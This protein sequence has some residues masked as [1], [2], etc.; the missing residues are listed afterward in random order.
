MLYFSNG[1]AVVV[2]GLVFIGWFMGKDLMGTEVI[3]GGVFGWVAT[4]HGF[5]YWKAKAENL[6]KMKRDNP[7]EFDAVQTGGQTYDIQ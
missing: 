3:I 2:T 5:Y 1:F 6:I 7:N 4:A